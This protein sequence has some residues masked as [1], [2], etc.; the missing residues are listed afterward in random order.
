MAEVT[1]AANNGDLGGGERMLVRHAEALLALGHRVTVVAPSGGELLDHL[2]DAGL[3]HVAIP[4]G[5]RPAHMRH[6]RAWDRAERRGL[7]WCHGLVP[8]V[9]T[10]GHGDRIVHLHQHPRSP[11]QAAALVA[12]RR[13]ALAVLV[14]S[15]AMTTLVRNARVHLNWTEDLPL[16]TRPTPSPTLRIGY[17]GRL[18][19]D[20]G[21]DVLARAASGLVER[22]H[23]VELVV[24]GD[25]RHVPAA[26]RDAA[27]TA[28]DA[29]TAEVRRVG[30]VERAEVLT[31]VDLAVFP[32]VT[33]EPF[34]LVAAE[35][36]ASG[37]PFVVS[38]AGALPEV[39]GPDHP[40]IARAGDPADL[41]RVIARA[42]AT[43]A[44]A[45]QKVTDSARVRWAGEYSPAAGQRRVA[46]LLDDLGV[47]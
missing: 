9:A 42:L 31:A 12:A 22:G 28:L 26:R 46:R 2:A 40:W 16:L 24:A 5:S 33:A 1:L 11:G 39:A 44:E 36:M 7:L 45:V 29:C 15:V 41:A 14:P 37:V 38:D 43:P 13:R 30:Q 35:A 3:E 23:R 18:T 6:L 20:K 34:G 17:L 47:S 21:L 25:D 27:L 10:A 4:G 32:S 19:T 8:A